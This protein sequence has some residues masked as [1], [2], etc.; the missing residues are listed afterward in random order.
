MQVYADVLRRPI[1]VIGSEQGPA[2]GS[3]MHAAVAAGAHADIVAAADVH[4]PARTR[5]VAARR[6]RGRRLRPAVRRS[7]S[8]CTTTSAAAPTLMHRLARR[9]ARSAGP[10]ERLPTP[11][12]RLIAELRRSVAALHHELVRYGPRRV[13]RRQRLG[14]RARR[15][16]DGHQAQRRRLRRPHARGRWSC[17][18]STAGSSRATSPRRAT[19]P[20][21]PTSTGTCPRSAASSTPTPPTPWPGRPGASRCRAC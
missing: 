1:H 15:R 7:T 18:T 17:A 14:P 19:P 10:D 2:L 8:S 20:R 21:T 16:P 12:W 11:S 4:G 3:A 6:R 13:D 9:C 5:R